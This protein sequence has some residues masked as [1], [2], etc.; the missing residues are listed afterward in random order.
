MSPV[1]WNWVSAPEIHARQYPVQFISIYLLDLPI[2]IA[3]NCWYSASYPN[4]RLLS[5]ESPS[6][7]N[8]GLPGEAAAQ[9]QHRIKA[10]TPRKNEVPREARG[11]GGIEQTSGDPDKGPSLLWRCVCFFHNL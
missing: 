3:I 1:V 6:P 7:A 9:T 8:Q 10:K 11:G 4:G 5:L 2:R